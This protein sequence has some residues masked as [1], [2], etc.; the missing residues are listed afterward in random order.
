MS[1]RDELLAQWWVGDPFRPTEEALRYYEI[2][3]AIAARLQ[4]VSICEI[5]VRAGYSAFAFLSAAPRAKFLGIDQGTHGVADIH[6]ASS[7]ATNARRILGEQ[8]QFLW[9]NSRALR[10]LPLING[11]YPYE[12][13]HVDAD[14][15]FAG[16]SHDLML[17]RDAQYILVDDFDVGPE[18]RAA[19]REFLLG[20]PGQW[21]AEYIPDGFRGNLL[22]LRE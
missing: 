20:R 19:C 4:P 8:A 14:H 13:V 16:C 7:C 18:V 12:F 5:G 6:E 22:L 17:A 15:T 1:F 21:R 11:L 2:K 10:A 3:H 9:R